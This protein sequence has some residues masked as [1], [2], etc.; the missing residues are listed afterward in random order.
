MK[1]I[2]YLLFLLFTVQ[3]NAQLLPEK[4][5]SLMEEMWEKNYKEKLK[6][7]DKKFKGNEKDPWYYWFKAD[8]YGME[9]DDANARL[10]Y[11]KSVEVD[12]TFAAGYGSY[13][14]YL[15]NNVDGD[16]EKAVELSTKAIELDRT[17]FYYY[18]DRAEAY[19]KLKKYD[20][21]LSDAFFYIDQ[22]G[23]FVFVGQIVLI[24]CYIE[25]NDQAKLKEL[26]MSFAVN[27]IDFMAGPELATTIG[28]YYLSYG[29]QERACGAFRVAA[30][31]YDMLGGEAPNDF[32][33][34]L[35]K[36]E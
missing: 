34:K 28:N 26:L 24:N 8:V 31:N 10:C 15:V 36:C 17:E 25:Q 29:D 13:A 18:I 12:P 7:L 21:A 1:K 2:L 4:Y 33:E 30:E 11:E 20:E 19:L 32:Q 3:L 14:R 22:D 5:N 35:K 6:F 16:F 9:G 27:E 23:V